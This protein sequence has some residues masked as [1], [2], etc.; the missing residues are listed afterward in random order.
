M[1][2]ELNLYPL[3]TAGKNIERAFLEDEIDEQ[4]LRDTREM[5]VTEIEDEGEA[6]VQIYNKFINYL[7]QGTGENKVVGAIDKEIERLKNLKQFYIKGFERFSKNVV[8]VMRSCGI[9]SGQSNGVQTESG[10]IIFLRKSTREIK[11]NPE[12]VSSEYQIYKFKPFQLSFEEYSQ[13]P[14]GLKEKLQISEISIDKKPFQE[15]FG[16]FEKEECYNLKIK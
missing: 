10:R 13:L 4:T 12:E 6:I 8:E 15:V 7:G 1:S 2:R 9:E 11:P 14:D 16:D 3:S 5:L